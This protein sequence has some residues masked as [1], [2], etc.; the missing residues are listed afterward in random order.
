MHETS[1]ASAQTALN[2]YE[3]GWHTQAWWALAFAL[4]SVLFGA[5]ALLSPSI[6]LSGK[7]PGWAK[8]GATAAVIVGLIAALLAILTITGVIGGHIVAPSTAS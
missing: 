6:L 7:T 3:N 5:G 8:A 2:M 1:Q 4:G